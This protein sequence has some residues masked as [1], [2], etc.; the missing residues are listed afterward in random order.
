M[1]LTVVFDLDG[2]LID[3]APDLIHACNH[4]MREAGLGP[5]PETVLRP[6]ISFGSRQM[7]QA[8]LAH[9]GRTL[10]G[11]QVDV[12]WRS[13]LA[14]YEANIAVDSRPYDGALAVLDRLQDSGALLGVCTNKLEGL[15]RQLLDAL[16]LSKRFATICGRDTFSFCKP[17]PRHLTGTISNA[18]GSTMRAIM[19]GDSETDVQ[20]ARKAGIPIIGV[21][22]GY[23]DIPMEKLDPDA[24]IQHY[25]GFQQALE[26]L[27]V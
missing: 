25:D 27:K 22:F 5:V 12:M 1:Q 16:D 23:T 9:H 17:D 3:T 8:G 20:T 4:V 10:P 7:I 2:T 6:Q 19:V 24:F 13:F 21:G 11:A 18:G 26:E 15:S 14:Y